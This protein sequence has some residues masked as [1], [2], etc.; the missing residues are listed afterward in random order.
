MGGLGSLNIGLQSEPKHGFTSEGQIPSLLFDKSDPNVI[1]SPNAT[2]LL[3]FYSTLNE[4]DKNRFAAFLISELRQDSDYVSI[5]Y[6]I[7]FVLYRIG[8]LIDSLIMARKA[9]VGDDKHGYSN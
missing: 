9:L 3:R 4:E 7:F 6:F 1:L 8:R 2:L 5:A